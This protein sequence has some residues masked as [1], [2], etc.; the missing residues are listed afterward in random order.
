MFQ[1]LEALCYMHA[2]LSYENKSKCVL[3]EA[4]GVF[5]RTESGFLL[6]LPLLVVLVR[7][8]IAVMEHHDQGPL[9]EESVCS[10]YTSRYSPLREIRAGTTEIKDHMCA[11]CIVFQ[12]SQE[13]G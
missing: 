12:E 1:W 9:G 8:P 2:I 3:H 5:C 6:L 10:C 7:V 13:N 11:G 4:S